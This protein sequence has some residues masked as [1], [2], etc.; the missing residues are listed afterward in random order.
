MVPHGGSCM[1]SSI[2]IITT[3]FYNFQHK[4]IKNYYMRSFLEQQILVVK[5]FVFCFKCLDLFSDCS[6]KLI[7]YGQI[8]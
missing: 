8:F 5:K 6:E 3:N 4:Y 2:I 7:T 1:I